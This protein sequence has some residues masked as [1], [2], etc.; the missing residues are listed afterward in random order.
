M[1]EEDEEDINSIQYD[2][3]DLL[4]KNEGKLLLVEKEKTEEIN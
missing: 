3:V 4:D 1:M 2:V